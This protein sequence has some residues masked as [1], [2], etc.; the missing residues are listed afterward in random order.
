LADYAPF[1]ADPLDEG[2]RVACRIE[3]DGSHYHGWQAQPHLDV[4]TVQED[5]EEGLA[6]V[7]AQAV[8][9]HCAG[10]TDTGVHG[11]GQ[12]VHFDAPAVRSAK[13][14]IVGTNANLPPH[15]RVHWA[16][17]VAA[18][19]HARFSALARRYRY[20]VANTP[21]RP[22]LLVGQVTW[23]RRT[24][25]AAC[26]HQAAQALLGERDFSAFRAAACQSITS[27]R[28]VHAIRVD[29][30]GDLVVIDIKAN[31]YTIDGGIKFTSPGRSVQ[32]ILI[33]KGN[34]HI[35]VDD[36]ILVSGAEPKMTSSFKLSQNYPNPVNVT[37][38]IKYQLHKSAFVTLKVF[39]LQGREIVTLVNEY[40][41]VGD[42]SV[43]F[44]ASGLQSGVYFYRIEAGQYYDIKKLLVIK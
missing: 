20:I 13:S 16:V 7:A 6:A 43:Q 41:N 11:F 5:L 32:M 38:F 8:R 22:A 15:L 3:Y 40:Q 36:S 9:V 33:E 42:H 4:A 31:A 35:Y 30:V 28:N 37:T 19:F 10:R 26:M 18:D 34:N 44:N 21:V 27:M 25:D 17:P 24:L 2:G 39:D 1:P 29:R 12:V 14:W 23:Y